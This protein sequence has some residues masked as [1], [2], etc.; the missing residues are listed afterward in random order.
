MTSL[1]CSRTQS[2]SMQRPWWWVGTLTTCS[3]F[4][5]R[6]YSKKGFVFVVYALHSTLGHWDHTLS[7]RIVSAAQGCLPGMSRWSWWPWKVVQRAVT[8]LT[9]FLSASPVTSVRLSGLHFCRPPLVLS[10]VFPIVRA[11]LGKRLAKRIRVHSRSNQ[12]ELDEFGLHKDIIPVE[13]GGEV[14]LNHA[15]WLENRRQLGK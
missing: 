5:A 13:I 4:L 7:K 3:K 2:K 8:W 1:N 6:K 12:T 10:T 14:V 11:L 15:K 9:V